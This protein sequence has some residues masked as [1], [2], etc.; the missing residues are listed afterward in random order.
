MPKL[1]DVARVID[2]E[3]FGLP[4]HDLGEFGATERDEARFIARLVVEALRE[5]TA[6]MVGATDDLGSPGSDI[7]GDPGTPASARDVWEA[8]IDALLEETA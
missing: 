7:F 3:A 6:A 1:D 5:P 8:M 2:P 4:P